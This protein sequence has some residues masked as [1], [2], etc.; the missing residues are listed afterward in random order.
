MEG[1][2][3]KEIPEHIQGMKEMML[4]KSDIDQIK[5]VHEIIDDTPYKTKNYMKYMH[6]EYHIVHNKKQIIDNC[7]RKYKLRVN[8][9]KLHKQDIF[10]VIENRHSLRDFDNRTVD[11]E[12]FSNIIHFSFGV[13]YFG[14][15]PYDQKQFPFKY[16]NSQ[17]GLNYLDLF[18]FINNVEGVE[19]G[20]YYFDFIE[21][22]LCLV[23][24]GN[25]RILINDTHFQN[26]FTVYSNFVCV[27]VAD[28]ERVVPKYYKRAYRFAH[29]DSGILLSYLQLLAEHHGLGSC[30]VAGYLEHKLEDI[31]A[32]GSNDYPIVSM[33]FGYKSADI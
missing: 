9:E 31:L 33:C 17:G 14:V 4:E 3:I 30:A 18:I 6:D 26:E 1:T 22:E 11:F 32:L 21:D 16:T 2:R 25:M 23:D 27:I 29:V 15:G 28:M 5:V 20:L 10:D 8:K 24:H 12:T 13:K 19:K 7:I